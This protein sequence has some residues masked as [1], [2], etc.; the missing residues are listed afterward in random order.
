MRRWG[1]PENYIQGISSLYDEGKFIYK[2]EGTVSGEGERKEGFIQGMSSSLLA[3]QLTMAV[4]A[5][6]IE[7]SQQEVNTG[8]YIDDTNFRASGEE[9]VDRVA[10]AWAETKV[11]DELAGLKT[12]K[13]KTVYWAT[14]KPVETKLTKRLRQMG[15]QGKGKMKAVRTFVL[16]GTQITVRGAQCRKKA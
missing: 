3:A 1:V 15:D 9:C 13:A 7:Q 12:N 8:G 16:V 10:K 11:F 2:L 5:I 14:S 6:V 4:W